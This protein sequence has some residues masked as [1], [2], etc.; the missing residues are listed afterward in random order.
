MENIEH[1]EGVTI[2]QHKDHLGNDLKQLGPVTIHGMIIAYCGKSGKFIF[3][4]MSSVIH[5]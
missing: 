2:A 5:T 4:L 3:N 1:G